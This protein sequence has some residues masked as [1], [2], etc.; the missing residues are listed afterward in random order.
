MLNTLYEWGYSRSDIILVALCENIH[1]KVKS[2]YVSQY[3]DNDIE[4]LTFY[5]ERFNHHWSDK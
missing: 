1:S 3:Y 5:F 4:D 2:D